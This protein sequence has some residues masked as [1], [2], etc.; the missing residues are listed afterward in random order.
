MPSALH[1][2]SPCHPP[3]VDGRMV[4]GYVVGQRE[5]RCGEQLNCRI[6]RGDSSL[7]VATLATQKQPAKHGNV[8]PG[9]NRGLASR[10]R[11]SRMHHRLPERHAVNAYIQKTAE[12][13]SKQKKRDNVKKVQ[14][15]GSVLDFSGVV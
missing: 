1:P 10:T 12:H 8:V 3:G 4:R 11:G 14:R 2:P 15:S 9:R 5:Q 13:E 7:A 6:S